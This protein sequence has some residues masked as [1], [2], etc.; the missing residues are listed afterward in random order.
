LGWYLREQNRDEL[1]LLL[2]DDYGLCAPPRWAYLE[3]ARQVLLRD[4]SVG[5]VRLT[6]MAMPSQDPYGPDNGLVVYPAWTYSIH[7]QAGLWRRSSLQRLLHAV[8]PTSI[9]NFEIEG[10][11]FYNGQQRDYELHLNFACDPG[12]PL[13]LDSDLRKN[14]WALP[15]HNL[16]HAG[17]PDPRHRDFLASLA[18]TLAGEVEP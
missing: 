7:V 17:H 3:A 16:M 14:E 5:S 9:A 13:F 6:A 10:S 18:D 15:Y 12:T 8:G 4:L 11:K 1:L 2:L